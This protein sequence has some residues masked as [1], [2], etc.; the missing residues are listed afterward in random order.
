MTIQGEWF[1]PDSDSFGL[2]FSVA[3][4]SLLCGWCSSSVFMLCGRGILIINQDETCGQTQAR[5]VDSCN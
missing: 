2:G 1:D 3:D 5:S 4:L